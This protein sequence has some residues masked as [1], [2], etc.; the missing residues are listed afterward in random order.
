MR[1]RH[2]AWG[3][4]PVVA[5]AWQVD[6]HWVA[7]PWSRLDFQIYYD[8]V[9]SMHATR[10][11]D[12]KE[13]GVLLGFTYPPAAAVVL[14]PLT[15]VGATT[16]EQAWLVA[17]ALL[18]AAFVALVV[19]GVHRGGRAIDEG[20]AA[21]YATAS[22][23][24]TAMLASM[25]VSLTLRLGQINALIA[26]LVALDAVLLT[27]RSRLGGV[28]SGVA[29]AIKVTPVLMI[30]A[31]LLMRRRA[32]AA[33]AASAAVVVTGVAAVLAPHDSWAYFT[34]ALY[35][36]RRVGTGGG[37]NNSLRRLVE[38]LHETDASWAVA[39]ACGLVVLIAG[40]G[41]RRAALRGDYTEAVTITMLCS[42]LVSPITWGHHLYFCGPA[43][44][45]LWRR[46]HPVWRVLSLAG[47]VALLDPFEGGEGLTYSMWRL[48]FMV[49]ALVVLSAT[50]PRSVRGQR[51][52]TAVGGVTFRLMVGA[53]E[54]GARPQRV[55]GDEP[56]EREGDHAERDREEEHVV[57]RVGEALDHAVAQ[58][59]FELSDLRRAVAEVVGAE[60]A[61]GGEP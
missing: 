56:R 36:T 48:A 21:S 34:D 49:T 46:G 11:Y 32:D 14:R 28:A 22:V 37:F 31:L 33:R 43:I 5:L 42:Y 54:R 40:F 58:E 30:P 44:Y 4:A 20:T 38:S 39:V 10:L 17:S 7:K 12:F 50:E 13:E 55:L 8:A 15:V 3:V 41:I 18:S 6:R 23:A 26:A 29:A 57:Q 27:R 59:R 19:W 45:L 61:A 53:A 2:V 1:K 9:H 24:A 25:P 35:D 47:G 16:A 51:C 52:H 60:P